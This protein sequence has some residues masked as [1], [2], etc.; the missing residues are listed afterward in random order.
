MFRSDGFRD[1]WLRSL[2]AEPGGTSH[3]ASVEETLDA[4][5]LHM[6]RHLDVDGL[7]SAARRPGGWPEAR[8]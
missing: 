8:N 1:A 2:G 7:L 6:E 4:L 3:G 5:A